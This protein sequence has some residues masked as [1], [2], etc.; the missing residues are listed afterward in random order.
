MIV[1][2]ESVDP[3]REVSREAQNAFPA[4]LLYE[5][6]ISGQMNDHWGLGVG[7][8]SEDGFEV[9]GGP[10]VYFRAHARLRKSP[11]RQVHQTVV[12]FEAL[13]KKSQR[14]D[15]CSVSLLHR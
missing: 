4:R 7:T 8:E 13:F 12:A 10:A 5:V 11:T 15:F 14:F 2:N 3:P 1:Q 9:L 6:E